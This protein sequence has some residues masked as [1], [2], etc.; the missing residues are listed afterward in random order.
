MATL[1]GDAFKAAGLSGHVVRWGVSVPES[2]PG[3][4]VVALSSKE[5]SLGDAR[6]DAP[7]DIGLVKNL[8]RARQELLLDGKRPTA[9]KLGERVK[10]FWLPDEVILY[11]GLAGTSLRQ[12]VNQYYGTPLGARSPH[13]G[14]WFLKLLSNLNELWVHYS[15]C[16]D[17]DGA[18]DA[19]LGRFCANVSDQAK[20]VLFD[21]DH[22]FPFANLVWPPGVRKLHG[23]SG[24]TERREASPSKRQPSPARTP[25]PMRRA[26]TTGEKVGFQTQPVTDADLNAGRIRIPRGS[27]KEA[28]PQEPGR[29][30]VSIRGEERDCSYNPRYGPPERSGVIGVGKEALN[31]LVRA[32]EKLAIS[33]EQGRVHLI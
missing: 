13:K 20:E 11:I 16:D 33:V 25:A 8:L 15:P 26:A 30:L 22:P 23:I 28:L 27:T 12:R 2:Q 24:A 7:V 14:G 4:Y 17:P 29:I 6:K 9:T 32:G 21:P 31:R 5:N 3:V 19:M 1:V 18:E 10:G